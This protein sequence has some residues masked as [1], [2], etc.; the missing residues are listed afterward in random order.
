MDNNKTPETVVEQTAEKKPNNKKKA[1]AAILISA[2]AIILCLVLILCLAFCGT[3]GPRPNNPDNNS[4]DIVD[5]NDDMDDTDDMDDY[6]DDDYDEDDEFDDED[7]GDEEYEE[8][9]YLSVEEVSILNSQNPIMT[10]Y[11][12]ASSTVYHCST[13]MPDK[14]GRQYT[15]EMATLELDRLKG[16]NIKFARTMFKSH[17][18]WDSVKKAYNWDS[19][20]AQ[21][22]YRYAKELQDRDIEIVLTTG[23]HFDTPIKAKKENGVI[24]GYNY[25]YG[26]NE[27]LYIYG[28]EPG[29]DN[30]YGELD[31]PAN[32]FDGL[33][34]DQIRIRKIGL[35]LG[36]FSR[37]AIMECRKR[38]LNN[39][40]YVLTFVEPSSPGS[41]G[42][43]MDGPSAHELANCV[44]GYK[45]AFRKGGQ[46]N[47]VLIMGPNQGGGDVG[48]LN[49]FMMKNH[50]G[51]YEVISG[52]RYPYTPDD[53][54]T[55]GFAEHA[56]QMYSAFETK[57]TKY[58]KLNLPYWNDEFQANSD[59]AHNG[60]PSVYNGINSCVALLVGMQYKVQN[61]SWWQLYDQLW[62][63]STAT[64]NEFNG[65][66]HVVGMHPS[67]FVSSIPKPQ[68][69]AC[70]IWTRYMNSDA[71]TVYPVATGG[72]DKGM[73]IY[74]FIYMN[75][76]KDNES[77]DWTIVVVNSDVLDVEVHVNL[78]KAINQTLYR[79]VYE[80]AEPRA[81]TA[82]HLADPDRVFKNVKDKLYDV[83]PGSSIA[84]YTARTN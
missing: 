75:A 13:Y 21:A 8:E 62:V 54:K 16:W 40:R 46:T 69:Y 66:I 24:V 18:I 80:A 26:I 5:N 34:E 17:W 11:M 33:D 63:D 57:M 30:L 84:V 19:E 1:L 41:G 28:A 73:E 44:T 74:S 14:F 4:S 52:H 81:S 3:G 53:T 47:D 2:T 20:R 67:L 39:I 43:T 78:D 83:V 58:D 56:Q 64:N 9:V 79:H 60:Q 72:L 61:T 65:G 82:G 68:Y 71:A 6:D 76:L 48:T 29:V 10:D 50:P 45:Y 42:S 15:D 22:F 37:Q 59:N 7:L 23:W 55:D 32:Y 38:G 27:C 35:R 77:G 31:V 12:G 49:E 25:I 51:L 36:E 70:G